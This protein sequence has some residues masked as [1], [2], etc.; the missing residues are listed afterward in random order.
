MTT[1]FHPQTEHL[2]RVL[3]RAFHDDPLFVYFFPDAAK[4]ARQCFH[5]FRFMLR[6]TALYGEIICA[7]Q[8]TDGV[9]LWLPSTAMHHSNLDLLRFGVLPALFVQ[10]PAAIK[11]QLDA[12]EDMHSMHQTIISE[13][14]AYLSTFGV[15]PAQQGKGLGSA[16]LR[17]T[18]ERLD[19]EGTPAYLDTHN[20]ENV[21]LY[22]RFGFEV[23]HHGYLPGGAVMHW[24]MLRQPR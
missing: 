21:S 20:E 10:G 18:L 4:R 23:V 16:I 13:P 9:A 17:P 8:S 3:S 19:R 22:L 14:H 11:R 6:H 7:D 12:V 15:D 2:A 1:A 5:S 24:G